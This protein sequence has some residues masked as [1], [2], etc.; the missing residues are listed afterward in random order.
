MSFTTEQL[1]KAKAVD[2]ADF[3]A[4]RGILPAY[5]TGGE[6]VY[7]SPLKEE[8]T[9]SF[10]VNTSK[11]GFNDFSTGNNGDVITLCQLLDKTDFVRAMQT[12][13]RFK[14]GTSPIAFERVHKES[15]DPKKVVVQ[16]ILPLYSQNLRN[17]FLNE[18]MIKESVAKQYL[19]EITYENEKGIFYAGCWKNDAGGYELRNRKFKGAIGRKAP[20]TFI[21]NDNID[22]IS[23][24]EGY[25][26]FL[27]WLTLRGTKAM[28]TTDVV[29]L[30]S[31]SM[32]TLTYAQTLSGHYQKIVLFLDNDQSGKDAAQ[33]LT[34]WLPNFPI[35]NMAPK[36]YP[37]HK[38]LNEYLCQKHKV[39][40]NG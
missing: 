38:D 19:S 17:Y 37:N 13:L 20:T 26:D 5:Q 7:L 32:L 11:N 40:A 18:R 10:F 16:K 14:G 24:F 9:P 30:N 22:T 25:L 1:Y 34:Q 4:E 8:H 15:S 31:L 21:Q 33:K 23:I 12:L 2:I 3:L 36:L 29:V 35:E 28:Y 6:L 27:S 39:N